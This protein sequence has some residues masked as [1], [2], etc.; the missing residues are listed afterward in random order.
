MPMVKLAKG[1]ELQCEATLGLL[2]RIKR[3]R[4]I[5]LLSRD[6][7]VFSQFLSHSETCFPVICEF[8]GLQT[9]EQQDELA[10]M[11]VGSDVAALIRG[12]IESLRDFF[13]ESGEPEMAAALMKAVETMQAARLTLASRITQTDLASEVTREILTMELIPGN[14]SMP[15]PDGLD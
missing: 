15:Q 12:A 6:V 11:A 4:G 5:D 8:Y 10:E 14:P 13:H 3:I 2:R 7:N 9:T 1:R